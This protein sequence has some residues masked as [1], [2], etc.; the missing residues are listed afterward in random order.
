MN[1]IVASFGIAALGASA[2]Q[3]VSAQDNGAP[4]K[5]WNVTATLRGFYDDN[6]GTAPKGP[7]KVDAFGYEI[8]PGAGVNYEADGTTIKAGYRFG[9]KYYDHTPPGATDR[10]DKTHTFDLQLDHAINERF[11]IGVGDSFVVGQEPDALRVG[12]FAANQRISGDNIRNN[13]TLTL[14]AQITRLFSVEVGYGNSYFDYSDKGVRTNLVGDVLPSRSG[15]LDRIENR[16]HVDGRFQL[17]PS[18]VGLV[19]YEFEQVDYTADESV[20]GNVTIPASLVSS[21]QR[22]RRSHKGYVGIEHSFSPAL[23][24]SARGGIQY[25]DYFNSLDGHTDVSP[26]AR[27]NAKYVYAPES[28]VEV[29][30]NEGRSPTDL[31]VARDA[32]TS[33]IY[34]QVRH[35]I[36]PSLFGSLMGTFQNSTF[37]GGSRDGDTEQFYT[38]GL[39]LEYRIN[40]F[41]ST[42]IGYNYDKNKSDVLVRDY[43]RN[44]VYIGLTASY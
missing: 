24:V 23:S 28:F 21:D 22:N 33:L 41:L 35:Q 14:D 36:A 42:E 6:I 40:P 17:A 8:S 12:S 34:G 43:D 11:R 39:N 10:I 32:E 30:F 4:N 19:G 1:K 26:Y 13:A 38:V 37:N 16:G 27:V 44:R 25:N 18:T 2:L 9:M 29:G 5:F 3:N 7:F 20:Q 15:A 31:T